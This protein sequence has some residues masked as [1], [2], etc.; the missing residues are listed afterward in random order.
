MHGALR[1]VAG[2]AALLLVAG[3]TDGAAPTT[4]E[5][6][7]TAEPSVT[8]I[9]DPYFPL[10]GGVGIDVAQY[11]IRD[12]Y[13]FDSGELSGTTTLTITATGRL[14]AFSLDFLLPVSQVRLS[15]GPATYSHESEHELVITPRR[16]IAEGARFRATVTVSG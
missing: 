8:G 7:R 15:T 3:C 9:G 1:A 11:R 6:T 12:A 5:A 14:T 10:D 13:D 4:P 16:P 2:A